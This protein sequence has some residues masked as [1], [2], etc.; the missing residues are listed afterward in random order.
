MLSDSWSS[1][2]TMIA[3][4]CSCSFKGSHAACSHVPGSEILKIHRET[5][6]FELRVADGEDAYGKIDGGERTN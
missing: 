2:P 3:T 6:K 4:A 5:W 1:C